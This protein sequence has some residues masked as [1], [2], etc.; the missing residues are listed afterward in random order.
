MDSFAKSH[1]HS[2][3]GKQYRYPLFAKVTFCLTLLFLCLLSFNLR[4]QLPSTYCDGNPADWAN[5]QT[6]FAI[7][8]YA[9][10]VFNA[11]S[12]VDN[13]FKSSKDVQNI[14][15]WQW[16]LKGANDKGD[17]AN[18]GAV[19]TGTNNCILRFFGD[20]T[21]NSGAAN[22]GFWFLKSP[23]SLNANGTF[24]GTHTVG[25]LFILIELSVGGTLATPKVYTWNG[26]EP[27][28]NTSA[29]GFACSGANQAAA[30]VPAG[31]T[32]TNK[33]GQQQ[34][35]KN[36]F[37]EG[38]INLC[39]AGISNCFAFFIVETRQSPSLTASLE[40]FALGNFNATPVAPTASVVHPTCTTATGTVTVNSPISGNTYTLTGTNPVRAAVTNSTGSFTNVQPGTYNLTT[41]QGTC[42]SP[43]TVVTV[44]AQPPTPAT[45]TANVTQPTCTVA[46]GTITVTAP[47]G[48]GLM[49][50]IGGAFQSGT[51][52][53]NVAPGS[54]TLTV[55]NS[56]NCTNTATVVVNGQPATPPRPVV[57]I[58]EATLC[59]NLTAPTVTVSCPVA[60]TTYTLTQTG[61]TGSQTFTFNGSNGPVVFTVQAG[62]KF[63]M[64][65]T[66]SAGCTSGITNC[67]NYLTNSCPQPTTSNKAAAGELSSGVEKATRVLAAP[68]P[69][70]SKIK[71]TIQPSVSGPATLELYNLSGQ[72]VKTLYQGYVQK[73]QVQSIEY[74]VPA[75]QRSHLIYLF[76]VGDQKVSGKL[77]GPK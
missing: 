15:S 54:Y 28:L 43:A 47:T 45:P 73:E 72:K 14:S 32:Y 44:N 17:I 66:N 71:F 24:N 25:D 6:N 23:V 74:N 70:D 37:F 11:G 42:V 21:D 40:D 1:P 57:T 51:T 77:I 29:S 2:V 5:F 16:W 36:A 4:A 48:T 12:D 53:S 56:S 75:H 41:A 67:D 61:V 13:N 49:Y 30:A 52:F 35:L 58:Q 10:D 33:D 22:I 38:A 65:A 68:N 60:G 19:L 31:L 20:R 8:A 76:R 7:K 46:T 59:G 9:P 39:Q 55:R 27:V 34:Y 69:F 26:T 50:S 64:T 62:K 3:Y 63:F 18:A